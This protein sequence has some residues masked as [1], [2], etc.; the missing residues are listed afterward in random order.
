MKRILKWFAILLCVSIVAIIALISYVKFLLPNVGASSDV[1]LVSTAESIERGRYLANSVMVCMDCHSKRDWTQ[2]SGPVVEGSFGAGGEI[3]DR[4]L[5]FPGVYYSRNI[6]P[7]GLSSWTDGEIFRAITAGVNKNNEAL[8]P[9]MP[10][11]YYGRMD[12]QDIHAVIAYLRTLPS[13]ESKIPEREIDFP[14]NILINTIPK[15][16]VAT[17]IP[18]KKDS[19]LYGAYLVN[20]AGCVECHT[21]VDDKAQIIQGM[22]FAG[23]REFEMPGGILRTNNITPHETGLSFWSREKFIYTFKQYQD[24]AYKSPTLSATDFNTIMPWTMYSGMTESDLSCIYQFLKTVKPI[25]NEVVKFSPKSQ[26]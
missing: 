11:H 24:S 12:V 6:T 16:G 26:K 18:N 5:G 10:Y 1:K 3:F 20:A 9:I 19:V 8:F 21:K 13:I 15:K 2:F 23:G 22:E 4:K 25:E 7:Y 14:L 17:T